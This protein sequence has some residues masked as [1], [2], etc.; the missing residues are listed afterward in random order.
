MFLIGRAAGEIC[1]NQSA[2]LPKQFLRSFLRRH[3]E[4]EPV[5]GGR[6]MSADFSGYKTTLYISFPKQEYVLNRN[7]RIVANYPNEQCSVYCTISYK[8]LKL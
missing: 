7:R 4:G 6:K 8:Y 5:V 1:F 3:F 2:A